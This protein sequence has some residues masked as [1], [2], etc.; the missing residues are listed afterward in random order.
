MKMT[1]VCATNKRDVL[2]KNF[3]SSPNIHCHELFIYDNPECICAVYN[4]AVQKATYDII[5]FT[6]QDIYMPIT[7]HDNLKKSLNDLERVDWGVIGL[8]G[9]TYDGHISACI[10]DRG[11][12]FKTP[13]KKP[14]QVK[15][16]DELMLIIKKSSF[17]NIKFDE[18][19]KNHHLFG[20]DICMQ[21][22]KSGMKNFV[23]DAYSYHNSCASFVLPDEYFDT[24]KYIQE[25]WA[26]YLPITTTCSTIFKK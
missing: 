9:G 22:I 26:D 19:I 12:I 10:C 16:I 4:D 2:E 7:F 15:T 14:A 11:R 25:K 13:D 5:C 8:A 23:I 1:F 3:L 6:H 24:E 20:T 18:N 17:K 21:S